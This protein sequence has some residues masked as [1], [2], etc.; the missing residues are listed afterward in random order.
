[1]PHSSHGSHSENGPLAAVALLAMRAVFPSSALQAHS[2]IVERD[3]RGCVGSP[4]P[5]SRLGDFWGNRCSRSGRFPPSTVDEWTGPRR[6]V[7][8]HGPEAARG[9]LPGY[10]LTGS[11]RDPPRQ[12]TTEQR[13][14]KR[15]FS[16]S[17]AEQ[18]SRHPVPADQM[19][20]PSAFPSGIRP[21]SG[22]QAPRRGEQPDGE[23]LHLVRRAV[24][25]GS[26]GDTQG[27]RFR[28][29][30]LVLPSAA[31]W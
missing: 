8:R 30:S 5:L 28:T 22:M 21:S 29:G 20:R 26:W 4:P 27:L 10:S 9:R 15:V 7:R 25:A 3:E 16:S 19:G 13:P 11:V 2:R 17:R 12:A 18:P 6:I 14:A 23:G 24:G 31:Q 1:M